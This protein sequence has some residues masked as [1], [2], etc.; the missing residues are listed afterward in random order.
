[1]ARK[2]SKIVQKQLLLRNML[3][4]E[5]TNDDLWLRNERNGFI[6]MPRTMPLFMQIMDD[7]SKGKPLSGTYLEL[8]C[9]SWD[10]CFV[11]LSK[12]REMAFHAGHEGQ[13][14]ERT[15]KE[16]LKK[17]EELGFISIKGGPS[18]PF[19]YALIYN[20]YKA[21]KKLY[22]AGNSGITAEKYNSLIARAIDIGADDLENDSAIEVKTEAEVDPMA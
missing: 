9:R 1:M 4:P 16:R 15:W 2:N 11:T 8:W 12:P 19:S 18:G 6:T 7:L 21:V 17:L 5:I 3:W 13:R 20:P 10:E 22:Q 14:G